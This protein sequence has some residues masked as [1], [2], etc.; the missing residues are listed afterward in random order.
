M[1]SANFLE[2]T[3]NEHTKRKKTNKHVKRKQNKRA[4]QKQKQIFDID[5]FLEV[6]TFGS[7]LQ[8]NQSA[9]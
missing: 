3:K 1:K 8:A 9:T 2:A 4:R 7:I 6:D 5:S